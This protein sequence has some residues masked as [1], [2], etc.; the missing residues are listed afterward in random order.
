M[1]FISIVLTIKQVSDGL[2]TL[3]QGHTA[4]QMTILPCPSGALIMVKVIYHFKGV[5]QWGE[6]TSDCH[7]GT[8]PDHEKTTA[9]PN[10]ISCVTIC[11]YTNSFTIILKWEKY[12]FLT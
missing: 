10:I 8:P 2:K 12:Y 9:V 6:N 11:M 7:P 3:V 1:L 4:Q 5:N